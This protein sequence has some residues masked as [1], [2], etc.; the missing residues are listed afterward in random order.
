MGVPEAQV[1]LL[2]G[3]EGQAPEETHVFTRDP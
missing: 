3:M 1:H 2:D